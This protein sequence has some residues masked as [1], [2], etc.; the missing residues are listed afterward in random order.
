[1]A[2]FV[3][4]NAAGLAAVYEAQNKTQ[5]NAVGLTVVYSTI[6]DEGFVQI[7]SAGL[8]CVYSLEPE[9]GFVKTTALGIAAIYQ[10]VLPP[11]RKFPQ[12]S[13]KARWQSHPNTRKF[14]LIN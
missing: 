10:T 14:P 12:P 2:D 1:M 5:V 13:S 3:Q 6:A 7:D 4:V 8:T 9:G 11:K